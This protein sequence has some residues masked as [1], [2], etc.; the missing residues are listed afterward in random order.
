VVE[1]PQSHPQ[2]TAGILLVMSIYF[3]IVVVMMMMVMMD[4]STAGF[5]DDADMSYIYLSNRS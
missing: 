1:S 3:S 2:A 5:D 4:M